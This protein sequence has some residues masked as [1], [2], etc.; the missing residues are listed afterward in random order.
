MTTPIPQPPAIP[1]L[2]N[3]TN[4]EKEVPL[5]SFELLAKQ[6]GDI[7]RLNVL[8]ETHTIDILVL[9]RH[10]SSLYFRKRDRGRDQL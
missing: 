4:I 10:K 3:L 1:F 9:A 5:R 2:G 8:G 7:Y 6:Y